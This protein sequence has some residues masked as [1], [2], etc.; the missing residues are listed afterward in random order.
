MRTPQGER[1]GRWFPP[2]V[3]AGCVGKQRHASKGKAEA[4][5]RGLQRRGLDEPERGRLHAY[6]CN[7]CGC[8]HVGHRE[9]GGAS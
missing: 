9:E 7:R 3:M 5:I 4:A 8:Y 2:K 6:F 1:I